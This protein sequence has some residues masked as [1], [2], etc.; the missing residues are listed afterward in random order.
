MHHPSLPPLERRDRLDRRTRPTPMLSR[1]ALL[2]GRR[3]ACRRDSERWE[4][5]VDNHGWGLFLVVSAVLL[6]SVLDALFTVLFLS[7]GAV[8]MNPVVEASLNGGLWV[9]LTLKSLGIGICVTFLTLTK[10]F[11]VS[12]LGLGVVF[13]GYSALLVWHAY[14]FENL[15]RFIGE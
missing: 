10:N 12:R 8:E 14:L 9:F 11:R 3:E 1:Y 2:G 15:C 6:L 7:Y 4:N 5:F 13:A